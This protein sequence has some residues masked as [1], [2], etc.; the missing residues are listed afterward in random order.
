MSTKFHPFRRI[1]VL[2][3]FV[4]FL[5]S[6]AVIFDTVGQ[7]P[8][9]S[10][11]FIIVGGG[12]AGNAVANR[13][14]EN[15]RINVLVLEAGGS[16]EGILDSIVPFFCVSATPDTPIDWNFTT[17]PQPGLN[18]RSVAYPR[19]HVLGGTS[20]VNFMAYLRGSSSD[21]NRYAAITGDSGWSWDSIQPFIRMNE[22]WTPPADGHDTADQF[23][24]SLHSTS[25]INSV[26]LA[27]FPHPTDGRIIQT[28]KDLPDEFPFNLDMNSGDHLGVG[29]IQTT[30]K[31]G[32][33]SSSAT[34]YLGPEF[35]SRPNLHVLVNARVT[36]L[37]PTSTGNEP[38]AFRTVEFVQGSSNNSIRL[39]AS[40]ELILSAGAVGTP[41]ILM[42]SG[43]GD[44]VALSKLGI[45]PIHYLPS[46]GQNLS[47]HPLLSNSWLV[48]STD[49]FETPERN[50]ALSSAEFA[51]WNTTQTGPLIDTPLDH[52]AWLRLPKNSPILQKFPDPAS[53]ENTAHY[54]F[55]FVNG[56]IPAGPP[57][58]TGNFLSVITAVVS[59][60][61]RGSVTLATAN[62]FDAP[63]ID[64][65]LLTAEFDL[66]TMR[67]AVRS[68]Q[69]F[70]AG[71]A[72]K[73]YIIAPV[74]GLENATTDQDLD[75]YIRSNTATIFHPVGTASMSAK[76]AAHGVVDP[77]LV[78]K[79]VLGLRVVDASVLPIVPAAHTQAPAYI[80]AERAASLIKAAWHI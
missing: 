12:T 3:Q 45:P 37:R 65:G 49:T 17:A 39:T 75:D 55:L 59:P 69:R 50:P 80:V 11:D 27:G 73:G 46:V 53:G 20:S 29:W 19:G 57:P 71:P 35:I 13:L 34:S 25:G 72:W 78:V 41:H 68:A 7:L 44:R 79:G 62:P 1:A 43:I 67:E 74:G 24:S 47:D 60:A 54:E 18:G 22:Q 70:V 64:P 21:W 4:A 2:L 28:T 61:S 5:P 36:R 51:R 26:S 58:A 31:G 23:N 66:L 38:L 42:H 56:L 15:S 77:D 63:I 16:N 52:L 48:N 14:S 76:A 30:I 6:Q 9:T 8:Q 33:R 32:R 10:Y 40:K